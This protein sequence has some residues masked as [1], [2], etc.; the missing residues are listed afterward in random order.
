M[1]KTLFSVLFLIFCFAAIAPAAHAGPFHLQT[2]IIDES[3]GTN[4]ALAAAIPPAGTCPSP[5]VSL[6]WTASTTTGAQYNILR[7]TTAGG[8]SA[9][10]INATPL[11]AGTTSYNDTTVIGGTTYFYAAVAICVSGGGCPAGVIG[12]SARSNEVSVTEPTILPQPPANLTWTA[13]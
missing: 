5:C 9:T 1:K 10:P 6:A 2:G 11:A 12:T 7:G 4:V 8:E 3:I 13:Q